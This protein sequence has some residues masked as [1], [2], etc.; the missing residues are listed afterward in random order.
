MD[1]TMT[2]HYEIIQWTGHNLDEIRR[3]LGER[4]NARVD[5][6]TGATL[7]VSDHR[8]SQAVT[9]G[10][11]IVF[12]GDRVVVVAAE[13]FLTSVRNAIRRLDFSQETL[14]QVLGEGRGAA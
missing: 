6:V 9:E 2:T 3:W 7:W 10:S 13:P 8:S 14:D 11:V 5:A 4:S 1:G 12:D